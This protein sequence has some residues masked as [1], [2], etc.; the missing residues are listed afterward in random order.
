M[1]LWLTGT[2]ALTFALQTLSASDLSSDDEDDEES[3]VRKEFSLGRFCARRTRVFHQFT[4][5]EVRPP[6]PCLPTR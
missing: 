5:W 4:H 1:P 2:S 3:K 6:A